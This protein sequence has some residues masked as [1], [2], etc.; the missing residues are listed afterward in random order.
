MV[1]GQFK[2]QYY[3]PGIHGTYRCPI[4]VEPKSEFEVGSAP[5][6]STWSNSKTAAVQDVKLLVKP[7]S[8]TSCGLPPAKSSEITLRIFKEYSDVD[9]HSGGK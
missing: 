3:I 4:P 2:R 5:D 8:W 1:V 7:G 9:K 6:P